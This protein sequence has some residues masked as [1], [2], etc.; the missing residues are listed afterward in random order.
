VQVI[1]N[2][3]FGYILVNQKNETL[4]FFANDIKGESTC[5]GG[6]A[7]AWP[8]L[9]GEVADLALSESL[10]ESDFGTITRGDGQKQ[11]TFKCWPLY[12]FSPN[13]DGVLE[14]AAAINGDGANNVFYIAKPDYTVMLGKQVVVED[15]DPILY[16]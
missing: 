15:E 3:D 4:Y 13:A 9:I 16:L 6:C 5:N 7:S 11:I 10:D 12:Y 8:P 2:A 14:T 1:S